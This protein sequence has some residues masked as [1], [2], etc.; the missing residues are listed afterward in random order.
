METV[1]VSV[2]RE[3]L[4]EFYA[5]LSHFFGAEATKTAA[6]EIVTR[7]GGAAVEAEPEQ[8][9]VT[10]RYAPLYRHLLAETGADLVMTFAQIE[11]VLGG[12]L[13]PSARKHRPCWANSQ[14][15]LL[16]RVWLRAGW[17]L[18]A[19]DLQGEVARFERQDR[20]ND[21]KYRWSGSAP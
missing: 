13:P 7:P 12:R 2:P 18:A 5:L 19:I 21:V 8:V 4:G 1:T 6:E 11:E 9:A 17:R 15:S 16:G 14:A 3:R 10:G 20:S